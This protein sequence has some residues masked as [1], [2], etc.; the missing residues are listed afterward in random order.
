MTMGMVPIQKLKKATIK[1]LA[2]AL[3]L[4]MP[5]IGDGTKPFGK[6][7]G[8]KFTKL[9]VMSFLVDE[10]VYPMVPQSIAG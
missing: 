2:I 3:L 8:M 10:I 7:F 4:V 9:S 6:G 5:G 1:G